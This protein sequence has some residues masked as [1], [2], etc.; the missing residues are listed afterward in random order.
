MATT[1]S[2]IDI[3]PSRNSPH[4][5]QT[6]NLTAAL[7]QMG[8][9]DMLLSSNWNSERGLTRPDSFSNYGFSSQTNGAKPINVKGSGAKER[10][11]SLAGSL[12]AGMSWGGISVGSFI[13]DDM[14]MTGT[15]PFTMQTP[16][17]HSSSYLPKLEANFMRDFSCC[18]MKLAS[19]H[20]LLAHYETAHANQNFTSTTMQKAMQPNF[21]PDNKTSLSNGASKKIQEQTQ[22]NHTINNQNGQSMYGMDAAMTQS[23]PQ[24]SQAQLN[25]NRRPRSEDMDDIDDM[26]M[27]DVEDDEMT[28]PPNPLQNSQSSQQTSFGRTQVP[29]LNMG[30]L[31]MMQSQGMRNSQPSTPVTGRPSQLFQNNP[32]VSSVNTP[33]LTTAN[34]LA[35]QTRGTPDSSAPGTPG[36][37][38]QDVFGLGPNMN[39]AYSM[40]LN[41]QNSG[42]GFPNM[43]FMGNGYDMIDYCIDDP[44]K[45][46]LGENGGPHGSQNQVHTR[47]G[48]N[49]HYGADSEIARNIRQRQLQAGLPDTSVGQMPGDEPK[50]F[51][52]PVVGCEKAYKNQN[53]LKY[54]KLHGHNSQRLNDNGDGTYSIVD[55][56][57]SMPYPGTMGMEKEK[58][59][60]CDHCG[61]RY[62]NLNG[63]KYHKTHSPPCNPEAGITALS[64]A[65]LQQ[66]GANVNVAGAG[67]T[68]LG[69]PMI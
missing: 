6:S 30:G 19:L 44:A 25:V 32:T 58:P 35:R 46:L 8:N 1:A 49:Q 2:P 38:D 27:D 18:N 29:P 26:E 59:Y 62:K 55:P 13:R 54:H 17:F 41:G 31:N 64:P 51:R 47:L 67:L 23:T 61:K 53:G 28:P 42:Y 12:I 3:A 11:E 20:E 63:L 15:S 68:N 48:G 22:Q 24:Q 60:K 14:M 10:R 16:S 43:N 34:P 50:P 4:G 66:Q 52:C 37:L 33:T 45:H 39:S 65:A 21:I 5:P 36:E 40:L 7:H 69:D 9:G 56:E 57:T